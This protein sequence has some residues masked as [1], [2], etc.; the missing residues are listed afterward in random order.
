MASVVPNSEATQFQTGEKQ[1]ET[2]RK[3]GIASG[4][5][6]RKRKTLRELAN[7]LL[8]HDIKDQEFIDKATECGL[9][10]SNKSLLTLKM[11][12]IA[13]N[14]DLSDNVKLKGIEMLMRYAGEDKT[15]VKLETPE[16]KI[17]IVNNENLESDFN[18]D[19]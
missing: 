10:T 6:K 1:V 5:A 19:K 17:E 18:E 11:F 3:A 14:G 13:L 2:A 15:E 16:L 4:E 7:M 8:D 9:D 12:Q